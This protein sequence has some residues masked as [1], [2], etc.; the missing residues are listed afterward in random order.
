MAGRKKSSSRAAPAVEVEERSRLRSWLLPVGAAVL[1]GGLVLTGLLVAG[2][3][4][5]E[6]IR[7]QERFTVA[8]L[9]IA[10]EPPPGLE[11]TAFLSEVQYHAN[12]PDRLELLDDTLSRHLAEAFLRHPWVEQ[13]EQV[14]IT[15]PSRIEARLVYRRPVLAVPVADHLRAVDRHGILLPP[16]APTDGLPIFS[17][18]ARTP[19]GPAGTPWG[20][21]AVEEAARRS[22]PAAGQHKP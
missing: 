6:A 19:A 14:R 8:F 1:G 9:D 16:S 12:L 5:R 22:Q 20:D 7:H 21:E 2:W 18:A 4:T 10:C 3:L 11:R 17:G 15:P 13:V